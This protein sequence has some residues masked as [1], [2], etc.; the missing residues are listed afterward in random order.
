M[1][2]LPFYKQFLL[3]LFRWPHRKPA[4][5]LGRPG[6]GP[7][8]VRY[9]HILMRA[10]VLS[11]GG[12]FGAWQAGAWSVLARHVS[13]DL[14][15]GCS[16]GSLNGYLIASGI[17]GDELL[18][19]WRDPGYGDL[20]RLPEH[21]E[22]LCASYRPRTPLAVPVTD[23]LRLKPVVYRDDEITARHLAA[24]CAVPLLMPLVKLDGRWMTDGGL[25]N[26]LPVWA[27]VD[28]GATDVIALQVMEK[29][30]SPLLQPFS[31]MFGKA[32]GHH[33]RRP[34]AVSLRTMKPSARLGNLKSTIRWDR[35]T[36]ERW[37]QLGQEDARK[38]VTKKSFSF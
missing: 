37:I 5:K 1:P 16:I 6:S 30:P 26:P 11:G 32:V 9:T 8:F 33:P 38:T 22:R 19:I 28:A 31:A 2:N 24:S 12:L 14:I 21:L 18:E 23:L 29:F 34:D 7:R 25:L 15:V 10:L 13:P 36:I 4:L 3:C 17:R 27:A 20:R 35:E